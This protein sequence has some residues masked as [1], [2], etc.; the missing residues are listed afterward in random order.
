MHPPHDVMHASALVSNARVEPDGV[1]LYSRPV[2]VWFAHSAFSAEI[3]LRFI[4]GFDYLGRRL[5]RVQQ[6]FK[7]IRAHGSSPTL[8]LHGGSWFLRFGRGVISG[9]S[10]RRW[11]RRDCTGSH[12]RHAAVVAGRIGRMC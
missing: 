2:G 3:D 9:Q 7:F 6:G 4:D 10:R 1:D 5:H 8:H 12:D 11:G